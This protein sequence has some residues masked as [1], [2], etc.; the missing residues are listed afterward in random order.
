LSASRPS[1]FTYD[2]RV[3]GTHR[4]GGWVNPLAGLDAEEEYK[5]LKV[6]SIKV[7]AHLDT[8]HHGPPHPFK[9]GGVVEAILTGIHN[10]MVKCLFAVNTSCM[11]KGFRC[12]CI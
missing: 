10:A 6:A 9:Y 3:L 5:V 4:K 7:D 2:E 11:Y 8:S 1:R 12:P